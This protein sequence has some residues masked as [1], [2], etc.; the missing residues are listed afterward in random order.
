MNLENTTRRLIRQRENGVIFPYM[1]V[2]RP[3]LCRLRRSVVLS[4][5]IQIVVK[6]NIYK[7]TYDYNVRHYD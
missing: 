6:E 1:G 7:S 3:Y 4:K 2:A 5:S